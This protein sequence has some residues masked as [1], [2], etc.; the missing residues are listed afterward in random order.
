ME[1]VYIARVKG[2]DEKDFL[3]SLLQ[4]AFSSKK[5]KKTIK[6]EKHTYCMSATGPPCIKVVLFPSNTSSN[7][8]TICLQWGSEHPFQ[9]WNF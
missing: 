2:G 5:E 8:V 4:N 7:K 6:T 3:G 1:G 9:N